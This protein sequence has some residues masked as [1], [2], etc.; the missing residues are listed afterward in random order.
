MLLCGVL[1]LL[2]ASGSVGAQAADT[3]RGPALP[4]PRDTFLGLDKPKHFLL[5]FFIESGSFG[6]IQGGGGS[7][8]SSFIGASALTSVFGV[9]REIHDRRTKGLFSLGDLAWDAL[10]AGTAVLM[11]RH[12]YR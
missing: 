4:P 8:R 5:S 2:A 10:G 12:T 6:V 1:A 7:R 9:A 3:T 11:L